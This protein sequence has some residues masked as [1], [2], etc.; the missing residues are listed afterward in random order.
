MNTEG[1]SDG[2][3]FAEHIGACLSRL[4]EYQR[5]APRQQDRVPPLRSVL[6]L[7]RSA[8]V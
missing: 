7:V 6:H 3:E 5:D 8:S 4:L 2:P 1:L